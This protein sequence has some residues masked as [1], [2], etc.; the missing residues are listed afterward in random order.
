M[1]YP[2][3]TK[4]LF[5]GSTVQVR[6][7]D[8]SMGADKKDFGKGF[9]MT[10]SRIQAERFV[11]TKAKRYN[12]KTGFVS[13]FEYTH[14]PKVLIRNFDKPDGEWL[15]FILEKRGFINVKNEA[16]YGAKIFD[17]VIGPVANDAV[18]VV[19]NQLLIGTYGDPG[20]QEARDTAIRLLETSTLHN[21]IFFGTELAVSCLKYREAYEIGID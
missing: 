16:P 12:L 6:D 15:S 21:Q 3:L 19:L 11:F 1:N 7:I 18:G 10:D 2:E 4:L 9:Y 5:H 13:V 14:N 8:L 20:S 17:V